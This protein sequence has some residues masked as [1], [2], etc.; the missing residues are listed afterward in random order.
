[1][2]DNDELRRYLK[3]AATELYETK[4]QLRALTDR[5]REPIAIVGMACRYP[6]GVRSAEDLWRVTADGVDAIGG[7]PA[8]RGWDLDR[9]FNPDPDAP[10]GIYTRDG[11]FLDAVGDFDAAFFGIGPREA[12]AMDP[13]QRL[14]LEASWEALEDAGIDPMSLRGGDT[15]VFAGVIHQNYG[16]RIGGPNIT[17]ETEGHAYLGVSNAV[18]SGRIA[19][20]FGFQGPAISVDTACSSSLVALHLAC[21][22]LRQGDTSLALAGGVTVMS[23]PSLLIAFARQRALS[24]DARCKAFAAAA[25]GTGF[26]EGLGVLVL[27]RLSDAQRL[28]HTVLAVIR[29]SAV[30][31]D[32]ASNGLTAPNGPSQERVI[33]AALANAGLTPSDIDAVE[34][35]GTGTMLGDPIEASALIGAYGKREGE[36]LRV[37]SLK[38]NIGHTSAAAGVGGVIKMVQAMRHGVLPKTL[39]VDEPTPH[40]DWSSGKVRLLQDSEP[41]PV[42][43][44]VRR[45]GVSSFGASGT[46]AH[47]I[48]EEA[49]APAESEPEPAGE[50]VAAEIVPLLLSAKSEDAL[51]A[52]ADRLRQ[53][54]ID[55]PDADIRDVAYSSVTSRAQLERRGVVLGHDRGELLAALADLAEG[56]HETL[57]GTARSGRTAFLF[58]GQ[59]AQRVGM[60]AGLYQAFPV[61]ATALDE[62]C[63]RF[64]PLLGRSL[65]DLM[66][67]DPD[68]VLDRT[69]FTQPALFAFEVALFRLLESFGVTPDLLIGHSIGELVAAY[70]ADVWSLADACELVA[71]RGRLM[72]ALPVGGAMLAVAAGESRVADLVAGFADRVSVAAVNGPAATVL[73]GDVEA[74]EEIG[75]LAAAEGIKT[76]RLR[77]SHAFHSARMDPMLA[78]FRAVAARVEY[79]SPRLPIVSNASGELAG[80]AVTDPE[81]WVRQLRGC[82]R[83]APGV[84]ALVEAGARRFVEVGPDA[85]L[86]AMTRD[87]LAEH[88]ENDSVST[89][90]ATV[91]RSVD[92]VEQ[93]A[94][95]LAQAHVAGA[96]VDWRPW[97][98]GRAMRRIPLPTY[99]FQRKRFWLSGGGEAPQ[100]PTDHPI[101]TGVVGLAGSDEW[102]LTGR[103]SVRTHPWIADHMTYGVVVVP[104]ATFIEF[105]LVAGRRIGCGTVEELTLQAPIL[106]TADDEVELQVLVQAADES[107][108]RPFEFYFRTSAG[109]DWIH[110]ATGV[111]GAEWAGE[112]ELSE[113][114]R[115]ETWP[116]VDAEILDSAGLPERIAR[117]AGLEYGPAFLGVRA[118]W[119]RDDTVFSEIALSAE[120]GRHDLHPALLDMV[121][122]TGFAELLWRDGDSGS[123]SG[124]LLFRWGG[125]RFHRPSDRWPSEVTALRVMATAT[126]PD[127]I[128]VAAIDPQGT[129]IVSVD[130][131]VMRSYDVKEF[132]G[133]LVGDEAGLYRV[134]WEPLAKVTA[135]VD[136]SPASVGDATVWRPP[137]DSVRAQ[138]HG[139]LAA[140]RALL[141]DSRHSDRRLVVVTTGALGISDEAPD[142]AAAAVWGLLRSAQSEHPDRF[143]L[144]DEDPARPIDSEDIAAAVV[145][146]EPQIAIRDGKLLVPRLVRASSPQGQ[147]VRP[148]F[149]DGTVLITGGTGGLGALFARHLVA[150]HGV[151]HLVLTSRRGHHAHGADELVTELHRAG[152]TVQVIACD[153]AD[154]DAVAKLLADIAAD[155]PLTAVVHAAGTLDDGTVE[156]LSADQVDRVLAPKVDGAWHL[157]ELTRELNLGAFVMF[158]S[159]ATVLGA[160]GQGNYAAANG[161]LDALAQRRRADGLA[162][163]SLAWGPWNQSGGMTAGMDRAALARWERWGLSALENAQGI[164]LFDEALTHADACLAPIRFDASALRR[165]S[166]IDAVPAVLR[167][168]ARRSPRPTPPAAATSSLAA[169]LAEVP[170]ARRGELVLELV[171]TQAAA[172]LGHDSAA[173]IRAD[174]RFDEIGFDSLGGVEFRNR[175]G[176]ATG[177]RLPSTLVFDHPTPAAVAK[178]VRSSIEPTVGQPV[179]QAARRIRAD[180]PIAIVGMGCRFPG[181]VR[182]PEQLWDLVASGTDATGEFPTDR[183][184]DLERL[185]DADPDK[186]GT[187]YTRRGGFLYDAG[188]FDPAFFGISPREAAAMDPQQRLLLEVSWE[189]LEDAGIDPDSLRGSDTGVYVGAGYSGYVDRVVGELEGYRLTGTTSSVMSGRVAYVLGLEG[190][191]VTVDTACS[192]SLVSLHLA[193]QALRQGE[194][195]LALASG[196]TVAASPYL[197]VDFARQRGLSPDGRC[198]AFSAAADGVAFAEGVGVLVL[199]RLSDAKRLGHTVLALVR[200]T[201]VN[202]DGA[203]NG[204]TAPNGPSQERVIAAALANAGLAPADIDAVEAHGTGTT[205]GDPIEAQALIAAYGQDRERPLRIGSIKSNIGHTV[206]AA[207][208]GGV[209]KMVQALRHETLP[210]TLHA[211]EPSPHVDWSAGAVR[212]LTEAQPWPSGDRVRR[213]GVSS[214]G[215]S[216]TNAHAILEE[217]PARPVVVE[218]ASGDGPAPMLPWL[219][220]AKTPTALH[221]QAAKLRT[222]LSDHPEADPAAVAHALAKTRSRH[223]SRAVILG[224]DRAELLARLDRLADESATTGVISGT[225]GGGKT[226]FLFTGQGAQRVGMGA[227][228]AAAFPVFAA[229]LDEVCA[230]FDPLLECSLKEAMFTGHLVDDRG[231]GDEVGILDRTRLTQPALFAFEVALYRLVESFGIVP[232][233][234]LGHSIGELAA[235]YVAGVWSLE[236]ACALVAARGRLM[237][238]LPEGGAMLAIAASET[239]VATVIAEFGAEVSIAAVNAPAAVV[240]SG[241]ET[242][243]AE[244]DRR[245]TDLGR[246]TNRLRVSHAFHSHRMEPMLAEFE[247]VAAE[248]TYA[249]PRIPLVSNVSGETAGAEIL[250]PG[251]W[252]S[253]VRAAVRFA[254]GVETL[255]ASGV[256]RFLEIGPDA[257]LSAMARQTLPED[258]EARSMVAAAARR[259]HDEVEQ[260]LTMLGQAHAAGLAVDWK[261]LLAQRPVARITLPTYAFE[262]RR[263][264][265]DPSVQESRRT[266]DHELLTGVVRVADRDE[267]LFTGRLSLRTHPWIADHTTYGVVLVPSAAL[268][269]MLLVAGA[270]IGC[271]AVQEF[272]L[273]APILPP[274]DGEVE[275]QVLVR[276]PDS[277]GRRS[278]TFHYRTGTADDWTRNASGVLSGA[279]PLDDGLMDRLREEPWPPIDAES[280]DPEWIPAQVARVAGLEYGASFLGLH[281]AWR[282]GDTIFS[283]VTLNPEVRADGFQLHP[284]LFDM[285]LHAGLVCLIWTGEG[286]AAEGKL[287]FRWGATRF[288]TTGK[289]TSL[290]VMAVQRGAETISVVAVDQDGNPVVSVDEVV[291]RSYDVERFDAARAGERAARYGVRWTAIEPS[292]GHFPAGSIAVLGTA[293]VP[294]VQERYSNLAA[295]TAAPTVPDI[296]VWSE[297]AEAHQVSTESVSDRVK[298]AL[299][300]VNG[301]L[302]EERWARSRLVVVTDRA[303]ALPEETPDTASAAV[304]GLIRSAQTEYPDRIV[305]LDTAGGQDLSATA[306]RAALATGEPQLAMRSGRVLAPRLESLTSTVAEPV[307][308]GDGTVLITGGTGGLGALLARHLVTAHGVRQLLLVSR[309]GERA[310]G[311]RELAAELTGLGAEVHI[312][313]CDVSDRE[314]LRNL[315]ADIPAQHPLTGVLHAAGVLDDGT[316]HTLT[317]RQ[318]DRVLAP[319]AEAARHLHELTRELNPSAFVLFSSIA[320]LIGS[321]GQANYAA[322]NA[323][324]DALATQ[325]RAAGLP[326]LA[327][328]WGPWQPDLGMTGALDRHALGRLDRMGL[329]PL[330]RAEGL[331][332]FDESLTTAEPVAAPVHLDTG[333][334]RVAAHSGPVPAVLRGFVRTPVRPAAAATVEP[335]LGDLLHGVAEPK[336]HRVVLDLVREHVAA[337]L[338]YA[339]ADDIRP[340]QGFDELGFD[341]LGGVEFRNRLARVTGLSLPSTLVFDYP[342]AGDIAGYLLERAVVA[343]AAPPAAPVSGE[344]ARLEAMVERI[345]AADDNAEETVAALRGIAERLRAHLGDTRSGSGYDDLESHSDE[346]LLNLIDEEFGPA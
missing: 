199:E 49:P 22:A 212:L 185:F 170:P 32:G 56:S 95:A 129:P 142:P 206:A 292:D 174:Q 149:G 44:R 60:G 36:P 255:V 241:D 133:S 80:S 105:L 327:L 25:D 296:V 78:E 108:R 342:T 83:F 175:L 86:A 92:E 239:E 33:A 166:D 225:V 146:G 52:Q 319:K 270:R 179:K 53:R 325:R 24:P 131:V 303:A 191:A 46:N 59:G 248:V 264:W 93:F 261:P 140:V 230:R 336:R 72:G 13:Q 200:G 192:S 304:W 66:F 211:D 51:R 99:A 305:L 94:T 310:N 260:F 161:F 41:W 181:G 343:E 188:D 202:Q 4:Q 109:A 318:I 144:L 107:G 45:A 195:S 115:A 267:W 312:A 220:S 34:A 128:S 31:Q 138:V 77:V 120:P 39:H 42:G 91:R 189:A 237:D 309:Q 224:R 182:T 180:E 123:D 122:H 245:C 113:R 12:A 136:Q 306:I 159:I 209:I 233:V 147:D 173:D 88:P 331:R 332:L 89:V 257:V 223:R 216:G 238:A 82:V 168:F 116:P 143:I 97:F 218:P 29:G 295:L 250:A 289:V 164:R 193:C 253:Q 110:N 232:D 231:V 229:A 1:M 64:D 330:D 119:R 135:G 279:G 286:N 132:R 317:D 20:T 205:L 217:A 204:L 121:M 249:A 276:E 314:A 158:S 176:K 167:G 126:G 290:R 150:E 328:A 198:K 73:S 269:E 190:P 130:A 100:S 127:T 242:T 247:A 271:D 299:R 197:Y 313:A 280:V 47:L 272:T 226:A 35:H 69:E 340:D 235:A 71:A 196:V 308:F 96:R 70:V 14:M 111:F 321:P 263:Y 339:S 186:P 38:S 101:L 63:A 9:L 177:L 65:K 297:S 288:H 3:K 259:D 40:V 213:A 57:E 194:S 169:Q 48:L 302:A 17:A 163:T 172:V 106:P 214:F 282:R 104:S 16:P 26:S 208:V 275:L 54:L 258:I 134:H 152:A 344:I 153:I 329:I 236:D 156:S 301:W 333:K 30:N 118:A 215:V 103:F 320:G 151:R 294:G 11:G 219:L 311:A 75:R 334:L 324:L 278:F 55:D 19:Y 251:Y 210:R 43:E 85:V 67:A 27:E 139:A 291:M 50:P 268:M 246:K 234:V 315:L 28:G 114:L 61:F 81:Y 157:H 207:G 335:S 6:G 277:T 187:V 5:S 62:V 252:A 125:A 346:E 256:R 171:L 203:S 273:E 74:I 160:A 76:N 184:W 117:R 112:S 68:G 15:G 285:A 227:G 102:L 323:F 222:W 307:S 326:A 221:A 337:V 283:E 244:I 240:V 79:R 262:H 201:A 274:A 293:Q 287:L 2:A 322:A 298:A 18:L 87:C 284:A 341:S 155:H 243:V 148:S 98:A 7:Y 58:T 8:D 265:L 300:T 316:F 266:E 37:G 90:T 124:K 162:A 183:G 84:D 10:G 228:L 145:S 165:E 137:I 141:A 254:P 178:L 345:I 154:R 23:D 338:G 281:G 21:Q